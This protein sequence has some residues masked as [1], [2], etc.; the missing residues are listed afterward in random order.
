M[1]GMLRLS[2]VFADEIRYNSR[3][4]GGCGG[5]TQMKSAFE[6]TGHWGMW[7]ESAFEVTGH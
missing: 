1:G 7:M 4:I 2:L 6:V 5:T 3:D